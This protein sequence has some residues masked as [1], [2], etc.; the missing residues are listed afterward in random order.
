MKHHRTRKAVSLLLSLLMAVQLL[1]LEAGAASEMAGKKAGDVL[2]NNGEKDRLFVSETAYSLAPGI[3]EYVTY[4]NEPDGLNQNIDY[5]CEVDL[6]QAEVMTGYAGMENI[7]EKKTINWRMQ[8]V[9]G[10][11]EDTQSYFTRSEKYADCT[12]AAALNAD[13]YN[14]ATGQPTGLLIIDGTVYN[15]SSGGYY[16]GID[17]S[18]KAVI[19]N[20]KSEAALAELSYAVGGGSL[21]VNNGQVNVGSGGRNVTYSAIGIKPDG[22]VVSM[23]CYGQ[24]YP[25]SCGY[26]Q[27]EVAQMMKARGC[28]TA[29]LLDGSGS[30]TFVSRR[31]GDSKPQTRNHPSDGQERQV[32]SSIFFISRA[33]A[34][35]IFD[36]ATIAPTNEVYT[37]GSVVSFTAAGADRSGAP[38]PLPSGLTWTVDA[39]YGT[40]DSATGVFTSNGKTGD[41][42][43]YLNQGGTQVGST[44]ITI[45]DPDQITFAEASVSMGNGDTGDLGLR[46]YYQQREV[47]YQDGDLDW[48]IQP[49]QYSRKEYVNSTYNYRY[50]GL[51]GAVR[52]DPHPKGITTTMAPPDRLLDHSDTSTGGWGIGDLKG[53]ALGWVGGGLAD[54]Y[55]EEGWVFASHNFKV[56]T[57]T[58]G[59]Q[60]NK[61]TVGEVKNN[62]LTIDPV[63]TGTDLSAPE[64]ELT[65]TEKTATAITATVTVSSKTNPDI[66]GSVTLNACK[67]PSVAMDF[68]Q[69]EMKIFHGLT[70]DGASDFRGEFVD[71]TYTAFSEAKNEKTLKNEGY[72]VV[73]VSYVGR[74]GGSPQ[75]GTAT[76]VN[77]A[78]GYPV[79]FGDN[80]LKVDY[81]IPGNP[82]G[83]DGVCFGPTEEIDLSTLGNPSRIGIW[84]YI[85]ANTPNLW[86]RLRYR[87]GSGNTSQVD[88]TENDIYRPNNVARNAD[89]G[90]H[91]FEADISH[92]Q[93]PVTIPA[94]MAVRI[95]YCAAKQSQGAAKA[96]AS[97]VGWV[98]CK[99]DANGNIILTD[100]TDA[101]LTS[102]TTGEQTG[103]NIGA[104]VPETVTLSTTKETVKIDKVP[105][106]EYLAT[107]GSGGACTGTLP[108]KGSLYF[109]NLTFVYG[110]TTEDKTNPVIESVIVNQEK[111]LQTGMSF[112]S[113][114]IDI[115]ATYRDSVADD[116]NNTGVDYAAL[117]VD[118]RKVDC[119]ASTSELRAGLKLA[120]GSHAI[121]I[122]VV[123]GYG[124]ET[125]QSYQ[126]TVNDPEGEGA[127]IQVTAHEASAVLGRTVTLDFTPRD[128]SV[129][130]MTADVQLPAAFAQDYVLTD[131]QGNAIEATYNSAT[132][133]LRFTVDGAVNSGP[134]ATLTVKVPTSAVPGANFTCI[135]SGLAGEASFSDTITLPI[136]APYTVS[137][138]RMVVGLPETC[139]FLITHS[140]SGQ[141]ALGV[142]LYQ[143]E[144]L[145]GTSDAE[146]K[147]FVTVNGEETTLTV[148]ARDSEGGVSSALTAAV[149]LPQGKADG[150]PT[151][152]WRNAA[153]SADSLN[154]GW[155]A[156]PTKADEGAKLRLAESQDALAEGAVYD[157]TCRLLT[158][159][160]GAAAYVCGAKAEDLKSGTTYY[161]QVGD[162][163][164]WSEI[165]SFTTGYVNTDVEALIFGDLQESDNTT[166]TGILN[167]LDLT[168]YDLTIQT[169]D[170]VD[171]G[172]NYS[173]WDKTL[174]MLDGLTGSRLFA[175]GNH[176]QD[177]S[178]D[179]NTTFY[180]QG[181][182]NYYS[183]VYGN[184]FVA[185]LAYNGFTA[186]SLAKLVS[187][188]QASNATWK[189]LVMHQPVYYTNPGAGMGAVAQKQVY[190]AAQEAGIDVVL[191]GHDHSYARTEP[192]YNGAVDNEKGITYFICGS[193]G[194]KSYG[195][196]D[197]PDFHFVK[198][199]GNYNAVY[200]TLSTTS[201]TL[202]IRAYDYSS[203]NAELLDSFTKEKSGEHSHSYQWDG[204][205]RLVCGC[206]YNIS[207]AS[208]TGYA[209]YTL[210]GKSGQ[211][212][213]NAGTLMTGVFAVGEDVV[214]HAGEDGFIHN[215]ET[216]NTA[217]CWENGYLGCWCKDC[218]KFFQMTEKRRQ[219]HLYDEDHVCT[220][221]VFNTDTFQWEVCGLQGKDI[222]T[223]DATLAYKYGFYTGEAKRPA[224][225]VKDGDYTL[226]PQ[227]TYGDYMPYWENN[228][229]VGLARVRIVGYADGPYYG[230]RVLTFEVVPQNLS[231]SD[232]T[233]ETTANSVRLSW[234][235]APG[236]TQYIVS[237]NIDGTWTRLGVTDAP[238]YTV[239]GLDQ[240]EYQFRVRPFAEV[241][242]V[243]YYSTKNSPVVTVTLDASALRFS[244]GSRVERSYGD[245]AFINAASFD[246][247]TAGFT[248]SSGDAD[249]AEVN[250]ETGEVTIRN[251][252]TAVITATN[253]TVT[254]EY[255][256]VVLPKQVEITWNIPEDLVYNGQPAQVTAEVASG[257][258]EGDD[259]QVSV[260]GGQEIDAGTHTATAAGL[261]NP[262]YALSAERTVQYTIQPAVLHELIWSNTELT[263]TGTP[264]APT[265]TAE[266]GVVE[267]DTVTFAVPTAV[268]AGSYVVSA[269]SRNSNYVVAEDANTCRFTIAMPEITLAGADGDQLTWYLEGS[270]IY[271]CGITSA[272]AVTVSVTA[273]LLDGAQSAS[274]QVTCGQTDGS[275]SMGGIT[276][277]VNAE[278]LIAALPK[279]DLAEGET[280]MEIPELELGEDAKAELDAAANAEDN[281]LNGLNA[282][283]AAGAEDLVLNA[284]GE[285]KMP[286]N[287]VE[288]KTYGSMTVV[289][290]V[291]GTSYTVDIVPS[292]ELSEKDSE[293]EPIAKG[294][295]ANA[296]LEAPVEV[297]LEVPAGITLDE[298]TTYIRHIHEDGSSSYI[299]PHRIEG[300]TLY[301]YTDSFSRFQVVSDSRSASIAFPTEDGVQVR[302]YGPENIG[303][304]LPSVEAP[305]GKT[306]KGWKIGEETYTSV[307]EELLDALADAEDT[308]QAE[309]VFQDKE[310]GGGTIPGG[311]GGGICAET[312]PITV[313]AVENGTVSPDQQS[314]AEG[315]TVT[316]TVKAEEGYQLKSITA[317][318][319]DGAAIALTDKGDG[320]YQFT[321]PGTAVEIRAEFVAEKTF[322][323]VAEGSY[324]DEAVKWAVKNGITLGFANGLFAPEQSC[325]RAQIVTFLWRAAGSPAPK[326]TVNPFQ[327]IQ[328][329]M[330]CYQAVLWAVENG[331]T[332]GTTETTFSPNDTCTRGQSVTFLYRAVG[333]QTESQVTFPDVAAGSYCADAVAWAVENG[334][335]KGLA[336]GLFGPNENCTRGQIVTFL[337]R[338]YTKAN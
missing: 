100:R 81:D 116:R 62:K 104:T 118:G 39:D 224:V 282:S 312:Y 71:G 99:T 22:T 128:N 52:T 85:P 176:E 120:N 117:Y 27:F 158:F 289:E 63:Y 169:G 338:A 25:I 216:I 200:L 270:T 125:A 260:S 115:Q 141:P 12:I 314:A 222:A 211:V 272:E 133:V 309:P 173:Y 1:P 136:S 110:S 13:Y 170:L 264:I 126:I 214:H 124:N 68:E 233:T 254:G 204:G 84:V 189:I 290:Y 293:A 213:F 322:P 248:Y 31:D 93:T 274:A 327:D 302:I 191:S 218:N 305:E 109:D 285:T 208:Y 206:G 47:H 300:Q 244:L 156:D 278:K 60:L 45:A 33:K 88:F 34:D 9:S 262:N 44:T 276:Y 148:T 318:G 64:H 94:G 210:D 320:T 184:V 14:M 269:V 175:V 83:T 316:I 102:F 4:T 105:I 310:Q 181:N 207:A 17:K 127:P 328:E 306:F 113:S 8:T 195:I 57:E 336:N 201:D 6:S 111:E 251:A 29:V 217:K 266:A 301:F 326:T 32:S 130:S 247:D 42:R 143:G 2:F 194:E 61:L 192:L 199:E 119:I 259:C 292:F 196:T 50:K 72:D 36:H 163:T 112:E 142:G 147:V 223:L 323:D 198:L 220:R 243:N 135:V 177:G 23:V 152:V 172:G 242:G 205:S 275:V 150:T 43:V 182:S 235:A 69:G 11:V 280:Q 54:D 82:S 288:L 245:E 122:S 51:S 107:F 225:T 48:S 41:V 236:A 70:Q 256:L 219:G 253:G 26:N 137:A 329:S 193:L 268:E 167:G 98:K 79:R 297:V 35:G 258:L 202:C 324:C 291:P 325:T 131:A 132:E 15:P 335:T 38:A 283:L 89:N 161:Y 229:N 287:G 303:T 215:S 299:K 24:S 78:D 75:I 226:F 240:G 164:H 331:V 277:T 160:D 168:D 10:Q 178:G 66:K 49:T 18:G 230:E 74:Q 296:Q 183:A 55:A 19:S 234:N 273:K 59:E 241:E 227:S 86:L 263:Y 90:W 307:T 140:A 237:Q 87:D 40:I 252:G 180:N 317:V 281:G 144:T 212:Y 267:G 106:P 30:S 16:F 304:A 121:K 187:D 159:T 308:V 20:D 95:M 154:V 186:E 257:L 171:N 129:A 134:M 311:G 65:A 155:L 209:G 123:D 28:Q 249:V 103:M 330:F 238:E 279:I 138:G 221:Q 145:L 284:L 53:V 7:L 313:A 228:V 333:K 286:E 153:D 114:S 101:R 239:T 92:L 146:G 73:C 315:D 246:G 232:F 3:T 197:D 91:Y 294:V 46:V 151:H 231:A 332:K 5:F 162:G 334:V 76:V 157:G 174:A 97:P 166:L 80:S 319:E 265:A 58:E 185:T 295:I 37:P 165:R 255:R 337:Y 67:E 321:M 77:R 298:N 149:Y 250:A 139:Y 179:P 56:V 190:T 271:V 188:A 108:Y 261:S 21:L 96:W 203:G